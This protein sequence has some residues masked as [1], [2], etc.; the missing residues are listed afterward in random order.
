M[1]MMMAASANLCHGLCANED[2]VR[3]VDYC[4]LYRDCAQPEQQQQRRQ[5]DQDP[6]VVA[7]DME[8]ERT[9]PT[10]TWADDPPLHLMT[11]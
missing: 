1:R 3:T 11:V 7:H 6:Q 2:R 5:A 8:H 9:Q 4:A 10:M